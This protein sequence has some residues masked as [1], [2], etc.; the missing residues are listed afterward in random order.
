[1][2]FKKQ[3][4]MHKWH[5]LHKEYT[6]SVTGIACMSQLSTPENPTDPSHVCEQRGSTSVPK[7]VDEDNPN[8]NSLPKVT[9]QVCQNKQIDNPRTHKTQKLNAGVLNPNP[10]LHASEV[11]H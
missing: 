9:Y 5:A 4:G 7:Q 6:E 10:V 8:S 3:F 11:I 2:V 1:M